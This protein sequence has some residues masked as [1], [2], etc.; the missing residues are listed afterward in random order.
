MPVLYYQLGNRLIAVDAPMSK[1]NA[2]H[3]TVLAREGLQDATPIAMEVYHSQMFA[4]GKQRLGYTH[5][6][7]NTGFPPPEHHD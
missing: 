4:P 5:P 2:E 1:G 7:L 6:A 3:L